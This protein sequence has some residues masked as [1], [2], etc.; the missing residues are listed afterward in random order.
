[1]PRDAASVVHRSEHARE[2]ALES[3]LVVLSQEKEKTRSPK[4][5]KCV[6]GGMQDVVSACMLAPLNATTW[7]VATLVDARV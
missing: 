1:M 7:R 3:L 6:V 2:V 5:P 4:S